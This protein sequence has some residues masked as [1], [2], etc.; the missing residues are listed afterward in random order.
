MGLR[1]QC[2]IPTIN[3]VVH[4]MTSN[5]SCLSALIISA[6]Q[7]RYIPDLY[8]LYDLARGAGWERYNLHGLGRV[9]WVGSVLYR[10]TD[11][12]QHLRT[13]G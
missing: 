3:T 9:S 1:V 10:Y 6:R 11:P 5:S 8:D 13:A 7:D 12:A 2:N 4:S